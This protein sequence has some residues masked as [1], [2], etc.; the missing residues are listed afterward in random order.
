MGQ[1]HC[2][3]AMLTTN[4]DVCIFSTPDLP[5]LIGRPQLFGSQFSK[6]CDP[7][8]TYCLARYL[9]KKRTLDYVS[10]PVA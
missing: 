10:L 4:E 7:F 1:W 3:W 8:A 5:I 9:E 6:N 2:H